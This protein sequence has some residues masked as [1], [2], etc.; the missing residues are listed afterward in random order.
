M[1]AAELLNTVDWLSFSQLKNEMHKL[2]EWKI[3][4]P[5]DSKLPRQ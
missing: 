1:E 5:A 4:P 3:F 2:R